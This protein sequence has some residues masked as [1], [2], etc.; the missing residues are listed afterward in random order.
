[1]WQFCVNS[2]PAVIVTLETDGVF[3]ARF[4]SVGTASVAF[5]V[6]SGP[7]SVELGAPCSVSFQLVDRAGVFVAPA[8][9]FRGKDK[10]SPSILVL[11]QPA[12]IVRVETRRTF[13]VPVLPELQLRAVLTTPGGE[14]LRPRVADLSLT[15]L[16]VDFPVGEDPE[17][18][19]GTEIQVE[20]RLQNRQ[21]RLRG[22]IR[23]QSRRQYGVSFVDVIVD[24]RLEPPEVLRTIFKAA[25][26]RWL[27]YWSRGR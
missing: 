15:G 24:D 4:S 13:R 6:F 19:P 11:E 7:A 20:L 21:V 3:Q 5:E 27:E 2:T 10:K 1:M 18:V 9:E 14:L 25:E 16:A 26:A 8:T 23:R 12:Q 22:E 17:L